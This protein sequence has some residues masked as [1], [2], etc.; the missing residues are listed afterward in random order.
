MEN[1]VTVNN[2][3]LKFIRGM[4]LTGWQQKG[5]SQENAAVDTST[6]T[7]GEGSKTSVV[8]KDSIISQIYGIEVDSNSQLTLKKGGE[9]SITQNGG[10]TAKTYGIYAQTQSAIHS[11]DGLSVNLDAV[12]NQASNFLYGTYNWDSTMTI[13]ND[14]RISAT[15]DSVGHNTTYGL[16]N[17]AGTTTFGKGSTISET[18]SGSNYNN[19][20]GVYN[21]SAGTVTFG[22]DAA[23]SLAGK[24]TNKGTAGSAAEGLYNHMGTAHFGNDAVANAAALYSY[25]YASAE[26]GGWRRPDRE[27]CCHGQ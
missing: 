24:S 23:I 12:G 8:V 20:Y 17:T 2:R 10:S 6:V 9:V 7:I 19:T 18:V 5:G 11:G 4:Q 1:T 14:S 26:L 3:E 27:Q 15:V 13:G 16:Y 21:G 22:D 25:D